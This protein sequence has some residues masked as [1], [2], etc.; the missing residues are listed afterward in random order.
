MTLKI[1]TTNSMDLGKPAALITCTDH[2]VIKEVSHEELENQGHDLGKM[3][4]GAR[5]WM[6]KRGT[7]A[8][9]RPIYKLI[10]RG[11]SLK[12]IMLRR[13]V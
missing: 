9:A 1:N 12:K 10:R 5:C 4:L 3:L 13:F 7:P 11:T 2:G 8:F 6:C